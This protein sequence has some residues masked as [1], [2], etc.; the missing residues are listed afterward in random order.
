MYIQEG[1][2]MIIPTRRGV[3]Q[4]QDE[5]NQSQDESNQSQ[6]NQ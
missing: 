2:V 1:M 5:S 6:D 3:S 4:S